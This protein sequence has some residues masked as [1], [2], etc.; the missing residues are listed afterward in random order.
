[1]SFL[2]GFIPLF[3]I[4]VLSIDSKIGDNNHIYS[5]LRSFISSENRVFITNRPII[6]K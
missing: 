3:S 4:S 2:G 6:Q 5:K 1:M